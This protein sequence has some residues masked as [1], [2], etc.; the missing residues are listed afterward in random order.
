MA[1]RPK[2]RLVVR[3]KGTRSFLTL[4]AVWRGGKENTFSLDLGEDGWNIALV[5]KRDGEKIVIHPST[6]YIDLYPV[7]EVSDDFDF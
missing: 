2:Y 6:H 1:N 7:E 3:E 4:G 5:A